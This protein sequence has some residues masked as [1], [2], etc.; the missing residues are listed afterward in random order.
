MGIRRLT[1][2]SAGALTYD[3]AGFNMMLQ[4]DGLID[5]ED[6]LIYK[7]GD[8]ISAGNVQCLD[9][10]GNGTPHWI[11][12]HNCGTTITETCSV[13]AVSLIGDDLAKGG[14]YD[15]GTILTYIEIMPGD[16]IYGKFK[17]VALLKT[18]GG[19]Y[20]DVLRLIRG[21]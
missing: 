6:H 3:Q 12:I 4:E 18:S 8:G 16:I 21:V 17:E 11:G 9:I 19:L 5:G 13:Q 14:S 2:D 1:G 15:A 20:K 10:P 7:A